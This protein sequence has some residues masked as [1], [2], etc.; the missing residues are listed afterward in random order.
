MASK[1]K[2]C[3]VV[4]RYGLEVNGGAELLCRQLAEKMLPLYDIEVLT[5]KAVDYMTWRDEYTESYETVNGVGVRR[6]SVAHPRV[7][8]KFDAINGKFMQ[9]VMGRSEEAKW[10]EEQGP[11][12]PDLIQ[13]IR[14]HK[15][16]YA[17][18]VFFTYLYYTTVMG[19]RQAKEKAI[20]ISHA[21]DEPFLRMKQFDH[22]FLD[23]QAFFFNTDEERALIR[24]RY[25]NYDIPCKLGGVG[26]EIPA[27]VSGERFRRKYHLDNYIIYVGRIDE[28][29]NC[30]E[31]FEYFIR[32]KKLH[33][34]SLKL[35]LIGKAVIEVPKHEDIVSLGFV[36]DEDKFD[37]IAGSQFLV[38][39]SV[40]ESLSM[41]VLE[42]FSL[43]RPV[44]VN[45]KCEV[46]RGHCEKCG[47]G[48]YYRGFGAFES[49]ML[50]LLNFPE[51]QAEMGEKGRGYV[52]TNFQWS[53]ITKKFASLIEYVAAKNEKK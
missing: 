15:E 43:G 22:V 20:V 13:Y 31:L 40:F 30:G 21:H 51:L 8:E 32:Y 49:K 7:Q 19:V 42:A 46:L 38:L 27:D 50:Q 39:P 34:G 18:F 47:G 6:F 52:Q 10:L 28:G 41:V 11:Y 29:K 1:R 12:V 25:Q 3:F 48:F 16:D 36:S 37:G 53:I 17:V 14:E 45:G 35:V 24:K 2:V 5:T 33:P 26:V 4:Q 9:G 23:P 44:L